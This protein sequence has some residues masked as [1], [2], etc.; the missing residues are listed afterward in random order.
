MKQAQKALEWYEYSLDS[1]ILASLCI[2]HETE[3]MIK[4]F[5]DWRVGI[6]TVREGKHKGV[7]EEYQLKIRIVNVKISATFLMLC[8]FKGLKWE[9]G[10]QPG[11]CCSVPYSTLDFLI[12]ILGLEWT[13]TQGLC[14]YNNGKRHT[15]KI[16]RHMRG[17]RAGSH[18]PN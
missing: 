7:R 15:S 8:Q 14:C 12:P 13:N 17:A 18:R 1:G 5:N 16:R 11:L 2:H 4:Y 10:K 9:H 3:Q 6:L